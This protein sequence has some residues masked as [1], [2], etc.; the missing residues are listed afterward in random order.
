MSDEPDNIV[1]RYLRRMDEK[2]DG[3]RDDMREVKTR[4]GLLEQQ[5]ASLSSR[6]DRIE[7]RLDRI[8]K[9]LDLV[10]A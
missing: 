6:V 1:L 5:Y 9:R 4:L 2:I 3:L 7:H 10:E 8:E